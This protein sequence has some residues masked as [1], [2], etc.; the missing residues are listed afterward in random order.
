[1]THVLTLQ[2]C[3]PDQ[4]WT[5]PQTSNLGVLVF[6]LRGQGH[7]PRFSC[8]RC[9]VSLAHWS[10]SRLCIFPKSASCDVIVVMWNLHGRRIYTT[11]A[12]RCHIGASLLPLSVS[13]ERQL[14]NLGQHMAVWT[15]HFLPG[16]SAFTKWV[17][18]PVWPLSSTHCSIPR[19]GLYIVTVP[20]YI[21]AVSRRWQF[22]SLPNLKERPHFPTWWVSVFYE[23]IILVH[24]FLNIQAKQVGA[25][26]E[27]ASHKI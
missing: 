5:G 9:S 8:F 15:C 6:S 1:M 20:W 18:P 14:L 10:G 21:F 12:G 25:P 16:D 17:I 4:L 3:T 19:N 23:M 26:H 27:K 11:K 13:L 7:G 22:S 2:T 24:S